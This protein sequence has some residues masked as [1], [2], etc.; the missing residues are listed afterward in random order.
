MIVRVLV[1]DFEV[2]VF[3]EFVFVFDFLVRECVLC[4]FVWL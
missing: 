2:F 4:L 1:V 3:D